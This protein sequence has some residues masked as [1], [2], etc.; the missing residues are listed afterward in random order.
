M[1][2]GTIVKKKLNA[3]S[4]FI[5]LCWCWYFRA[6]FKFLCFFFKLVSGKFG[7]PKS[8][9]GG[10][11]IQGRPIPQTNPP[12]PLIMGVP[13]TPRIQTFFYISTFILGAPSKKKSI[14]STLILYLAQQLLYYLPNKCQHLQSCQNEYEQLQWR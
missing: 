11:G 4:L 8:G 14:C 9:G 7:G 1:L 6:C 5:Q 3:V 12:C 2:N 13:N 10:R